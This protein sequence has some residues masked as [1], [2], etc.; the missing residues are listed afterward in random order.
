MFSCVPPTG[1]C[2]WQRL[3]GFV[4][5][6]NSESGTNYVRLSCLD[7]ESQEEKLPEL[8]MEAHGQPPLVIES[9]VVA[10]PRESYCH[11]HSK[12]H[13]FGECFVEHLALA[14]K[15]FLNS[16]FELQ[17]RASSL[18][19]KKKKEVKGCA[20]E[21]ASRVL[22]NQDA[23]CRNKGIRGRRPI[24][25]RFVPAHPYDWGEQTSVLGIGVVTVD[26]EPDFTTIE[27][28][29]QRRQEAKRGY[30]LEL[31]RAAESAAGKFE[32][33]AGHKKLFLIYFVGDE[34][35]CLDDKDLRDLVRT[36]ELLKTIDEVWVAFRDWINEWDYEVGWKR[37]RK[38]AMSTAG[39]G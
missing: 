8:L 22:A 16:P 27:D 33:F 4:A 12:G 24:P 18:H 20:E 36:A 35:N 11:N 39:L 32:K 28:Y 15:R 37:L 13:Y 1:G 9:K 5:Q 25:W 26:E 10:W 17:I 34:S 14:G 23:V 19:G 21:I 6:Y 7:V 29:D 31:A 2:E 3:K 30:A 38:G